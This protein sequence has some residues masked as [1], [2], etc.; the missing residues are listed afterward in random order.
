MKNTLSLFTNWFLNNQWNAK[1]GLGI[2]LMA[3]AGLTQIL[4]I[5]FFLEALLITEGVA[6]AYLVIRNH[7]KA[8]AGN[9]KKADALK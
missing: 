8:Q 7:A 9:Q 4:G 1:T 3:H 6:G 2:L 5:E